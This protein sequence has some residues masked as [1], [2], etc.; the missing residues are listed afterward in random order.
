MYNPFKNVWITLCFGML[1]GF[2]VARLLALSDRLGG[3]SATGQTLADLSRAL[4]ETKL[5]IGIYPERI[6]SLKMQGTSPEFSQEILMRTFY[7]RTEAGYIAF[8]GQPSVCYI[9]PG[10]GP[11]FQSK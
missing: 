10:I 3:L 8:V 2:G 9:Q 1:L 7:L 5:T 4:E 6:A 11:I